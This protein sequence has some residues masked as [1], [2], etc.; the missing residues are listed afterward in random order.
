MHR[1]APDL[2]IVFSPGNY[3]QRRN[4]KIFQTLLGTYFLRGME[5]FVGCDVEI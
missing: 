3:R 4:S 2:L 5:L 1:T